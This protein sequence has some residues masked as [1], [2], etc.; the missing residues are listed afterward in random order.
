[1]LKNEIILKA[2][3]ELDP[4]WNYD[5][6]NGT[7]GPTLY[8]HTDNKKQASEIRKLAPGTFEGYYVIVTYSYNV[9]IGD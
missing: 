7:M 2:A 6:R 1:M 9:E 8:I 4:E 3:I 5:F